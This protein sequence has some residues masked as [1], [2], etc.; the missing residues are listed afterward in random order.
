ML[1]ITK[2]KLLIFITV[3]LIILEYH[4]FYLVP[5]PNYY[6]RAFLG[7]FSRIGLG[8]IAFIIYLFLYKTKVPK[9]IEYC[10]GYAFFVFIV[11]SLFSYLSYPQQG[12]FQVLGATSQYLCVLY[13]KPLYIM[14]DKYVKLDCFLKL[15]N[16]VV[17]VWYVVMI[18]QNY[19][20]TTNGTM[21]LQHY[22][23]TDEVLIGEGR[24]DNARISILS[25]GIIVPI[26]NF[27]N[28]LNYYYRKKISLA[29]AI[30]NLISFIV[31]TYC[32][33]F[34]SQGRAETLYYLVS[35]FAVF[36]FYPSKSYK[37]IVK[38]FAIYGLVLVAI[39]SGVVSD[40]IATFEEGSELYFSTYYRIYEYKYFMYSF[41][42]NPFLGKGLFYS[43][44]SD[45][46]QSSNG[47][48]WN[49]DVGIIGM[50][51]STGIIGTTLFL[52]IIFKL[53]KSVRVLYKFHDNYFGLI[54]GMAIYLI[55]G[56]VS[57]LFTDPSFI[58]CLP[59]IFAISQ[60]R[61]RDIKRCTNGKI[62]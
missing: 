18:F 51:G 9:S 26:Y 4:L 11:L 8:F 1:R 60:I 36:L 54:L 56:S 2:T 40:F 37:S 22:F 29:T 25:L 10:C 53:S 50:L 23:Q 5:I 7:R 35:I 33:V 24:A 20:A 30:L 38:I 6:V 42:M 13:V 3:I 47:V 17:F 19:L 46:Y 57:I 59:I 48:M 28:L 49:N 44:Y 32:I 12:I 41:I 14:L 62:Y 27:N 31:G 52:Y 45:I 16:I 39:F 43:S 58:M 15:I 21:I 34:L 55:I 61:T